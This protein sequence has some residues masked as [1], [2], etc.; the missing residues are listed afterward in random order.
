MGISFS[1]LLED[2]VGIRRRG[3]K[4]VGLGQEAAI[5]MRAAGEDIFGESGI[6]AQ[7]QQTVGSQFA[8]T[9]ADVTGLFDA[10][11]ARNTGLFA[12]AQANFQ[13]FIAGGQEAQ[14]SLLGAL[15][16]GGRQFDPSFLSKTPGFQFQLQ[17][18]Q[19]SLIA[20]ASAA[21]LTDSSKTRQDFLKFGQG[22][23]GSRF[24]THIQQL[25][26]TSGQGLTAAQGA[27]QLTGQEANIGA[28]LAGQQ[29]NIFAELTGQQAGIETGI[30]GARAAGA[31]E[32]ESSALD[33]IL[34]GQLGSLEASDA[35]VQQGIST[36]ETMGA[37]VLDMWSVG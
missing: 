33:A 32:A 10:E 8:Q 17:Q 23:A 24:D 19:E 28:Q 4:R 31:F 35:N 5:G 11:R 30:V 9:R 37:A 2:P 3:K 26:A 13:P 36:N 34:A 15:G 6:L 20:G 25:L 7:Q 22:A 12:G 29:G 27:G 18:G 1:E 16:V 14:E 21:G